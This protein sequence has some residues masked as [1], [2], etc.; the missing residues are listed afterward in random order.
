MI[1]TDRGLYTVNLNLKD[2][3]NIVRWKANSSKETNS[4]VEKE[5]EI[6]LAAIMIFLKESLKEKENSKRGHSDEV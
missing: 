5:T 2:F 3:Q 4:A 1:I 6:K